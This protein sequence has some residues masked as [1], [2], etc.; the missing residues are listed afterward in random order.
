MYGEAWSGGGEYF[1]NRVKYIGGLN[2]PDIVQFCISFCCLD[3]LYVDSNFA[4][5]TV[6]LLKEKLP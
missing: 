4:H 2:Y 5:W 6:E 1:E 3:P